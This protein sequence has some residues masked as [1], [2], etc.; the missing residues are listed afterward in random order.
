MH[1]RLSTTSTHRAFYRTSSLHTR[2][3]FGLKLQILG[4]L[5]DIFQ[6]VDEV[7]VVGLV[8]LDL[9]AAFDTVNHSI[10]LHRLHMSFGFRGPVLQLFRSYLCGRVQT[11]RRGCNMSASKIIL[12]GVPQGS[13]PG[14][15]LFILYIADVVRL[16][17]CPGLCPHLHA[18]DTQ[19]M[20]AV[21][22]MKWTASLSMMQRTVFRRSFDSFAAFVGH[23]RLT[24]CALLS[25]RLCH[26]DLTMAR[27]H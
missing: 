27:Q 15:I 21:L 16:I 17:E 18:D 3:I 11:V 7:D 14:P 19:F 12:C 2:N 13:V 26:H 4:V 1:G 8:L 25:C 22:R 23:C 24:Y 10:L 9:S 6:A 20:V 5:T